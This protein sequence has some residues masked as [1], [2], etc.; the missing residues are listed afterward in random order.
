MNWIKR[1]ELEDLLTN[2]SHKIVIVDVRDDD[3]EGGHIPG[4][5][6]V[7]STEFQDSL[8]TLMDGI[9][10]SDKEIVIFHCMKSQVRGPQCSKIFSQNLEK[11][12]NHNLKV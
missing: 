2:E 4:A 11:H 8:Q 1:E 9:I 10:A 3:F 12:P 5:V 7:P 6:N